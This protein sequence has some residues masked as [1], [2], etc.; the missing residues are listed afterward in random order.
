MIKKF[1]DRCESEIRGADNELTITKVR[2]S[3]YGYDC[4]LN[5]C[6]K[7]FKELERFLGRKFKKK[8]MEETYY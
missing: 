6:E 5:L 8:E 1:C 7:C 2:G 4:Q 3:K